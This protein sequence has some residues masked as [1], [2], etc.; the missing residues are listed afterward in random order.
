[1][2]LQKIN[3]TNTALLVIDAQHD[4]IDEGAPCEARRAREAVP[5]IGSLVRWARRHGLPIVFS[6]E[7]HRAD[8]SDF[9]IELEFEPQHCVEGTRGAEMVEG[10]EIARDDHRIF[11]KRRYDCFMG[12]DLDLLLRCRRV[13]NLVCCGVCTNICVIS[14]VCTA[15]NLDYRVLLPT[16]AV[17]GSSVELHDAAILCMSD[18][19][20]YVTDSATL[21]RLW[22]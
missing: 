20:A 5:V 4:F 18:V 1:M 12:T 14:T 10:L 11:T 15:R 8:R 2:P 6:Q 13:E 3:P 21:T 17:A 19:F 9:G 7:M 22:L 16:D